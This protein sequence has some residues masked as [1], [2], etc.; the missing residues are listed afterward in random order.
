MTSDGFVFSVFFG[1]VCVCVCV[2]VCVR[3][4]VFPYALDEYILNHMLLRHLTFHCVCV[5]AFHTFV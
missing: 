5:N 4:C 3:A 1:S 2:R